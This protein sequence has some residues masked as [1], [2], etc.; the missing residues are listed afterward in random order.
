MRFAR[1]SRATPANGIERGDE[2]EGHFKIGRLVRISCAGFPGFYETAGKQRRRLLMKKRSRGFGNQTSARG[3][4]R[5][6]A[7]LD[8]QIPAV[9]RTHHA[10]RGRPGEIVASRRRRPAYLRPVAAHLFIGAVLYGR[11]FRAS[12]TSARL[13]A[14]RRIK[15]RR[16]GEPV[17]RISPNEPDCETRGKK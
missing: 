7:G 14:R 13:C 11:P 12:R 10:F 3:G 4:E 16:A 17:K 9:R 8:R 1:A 6:R 15:G 5:E 2:S